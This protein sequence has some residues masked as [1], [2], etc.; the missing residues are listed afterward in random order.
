MVK[1]GSIWRSAEDKQFIV[2]ST[3]NVDGHDWVHYRDHN[4]RN[5]TA[6]SREYSCYEESF[7][8]RFSLVTV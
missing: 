4:L 1:I 6:E 5:S 8:S 7:L 3:V 2:I